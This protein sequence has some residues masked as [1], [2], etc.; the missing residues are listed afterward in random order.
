M[1]RFP[2]P[3]RAVPGRAIPPA[4]KALEGWVDGLPPAGIALS[5][6]GI[7]VAEFPDQ[8]LV[9][10]DQ[11]AEPWRY[12]FKVSITG[13]LATIRPGL[14]NLQMPRI[15]QRDGVEIGL[16]GVT[17]DGVDTGRRPA[18]DILDH[19]RGGPGRDG[20]SFLC[21]RVL[22]D[23]ATGALVPVDVPDGAPAAYAVTVEPR[24]ALPAGYE[25]GGT[26]EETVNEAGQSVGVWPLALCY[27]AANGR[28]IRRVCQVAH[29]HIEHRYQAAEAGPGRHWFFGAS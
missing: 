24:T 21:V 9:H 3:A 1:S 12:P 4:W 13:T 11:R 5:G 26:P 27:W 29:H 25:N 15:V 7:R 19:P 8:A 16:D 28:S 10:F 20:R 17:L 22:V 14:V 18:L 23:V 2:E 6:R